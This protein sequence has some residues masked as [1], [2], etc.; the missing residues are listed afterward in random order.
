[1]TSKCIAIRIAAATD[2]GVSDWETGTVAYQCE[3]NATQGK[4]CGIC[5]KHKGAF[6]KIGCSYSWEDGTESTVPEYALK[7]G[8]MEDGTKVDKGDAMCCVFAN[9][10]MDTDANCEMME[11]KQELLGDEYWQCD[12]EEDEYDYEDDEGD[13]TDDEEEEEDKDQDE[14]GDSSP[15]DY[16]GIKVPELR[17]DLEERDLSTKGKKADLVARLVNNDNG[18]D[19][20]DA[21]KKSKDKDNAKKPRKPTAYNLYMKSAIKKYK[22]KNPDTEHQTAF[23]ACAAQWTKS[24]DKKSKSKTAKA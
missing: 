11:E 5:A 4:F 20:D 19:E 10:L 17:T 7:D 13:W 2:Y 14:N 6:G 22:S 18:S 3:K 8:T 15:A 21:P 9:P 24:K 23:K 1:M 16:K 12:K